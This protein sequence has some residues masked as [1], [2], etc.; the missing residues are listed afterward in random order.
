MGNT[1]SAQP[2]G[3]PIMFAKAVGGTPIK[4]AMPWAETEIKR[5]YST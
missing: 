1:G 4:E 5:I 3:I 2:N